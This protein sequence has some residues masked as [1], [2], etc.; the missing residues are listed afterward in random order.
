MGRGFPRKILINT[1]GKNQF[2]R[3]SSSKG[4]MSAVPPVESLKFGGYSE[5]LVTKSNIFI[6]KSLFVREAI[7][8]HSR[9]TVI[10]MP[11]N[12]GKSVNLDMLKRF[13]SCEVDENT[14]AEIPNNLKDN[15]KLLTGGDF[16]PE[17]NGNIKTAKELKI[18]SNEKLL[19][20]L[21]TDCRF[22][23]RKDPDEVDDVFA[24]K[25]TVCC[26]LNY[27]ALQIAHGKFGSDDD[28]CTDKLLSKDKDGGNG[29]NTVLF[30]V[31]NKDVCIVVKV[32]YN[33]TSSTNSSTSTE[34]GLQGL[35][36]TYK[37][38]IRDDNVEVEV[39]DDQNHDHRWY[40]LVSLFQRRRM[41]FS[42]VKFKLE[43]LI[44]VSLTLR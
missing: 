43:K 24:N 32:K 7:N 44:I 12:S 25:D 6:D 37:Q 8:S 36:T 9:L 41:L 31:K 34:E 16:D 35:K 39:D 21:I 17:N 14:G 13:L 2:S 4:Y 22:K 1:F 29:K 42:V 3:S 26:M 20:E 23:K 5:D 27:L 18:S 11:R 10:T 33:G 15:Y 38:C 40:L 19:Q 30:T 28:V